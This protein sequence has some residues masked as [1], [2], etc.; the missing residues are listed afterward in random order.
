[1]PRLPSIPPQGGADLASLNRA[2]EALRQVVEI[3][4]GQRGDGQGRAVT[5][6]E[7]EALRA[8]VAALRAEVVRLGS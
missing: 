4:A 8:E 1:M 5:W 7:L 3:L 2:V 6:A